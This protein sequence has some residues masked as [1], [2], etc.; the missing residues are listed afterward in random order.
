[1]T[2]LLQVKRMEM[3]TLDKKIGGGVI[4]EREY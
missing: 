3:K 1:M 2:S 4:K